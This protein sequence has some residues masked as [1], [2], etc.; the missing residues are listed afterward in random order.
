M[1]TTSMDNFVC[2]R[3]QQEARELR[4]MDRAVNEYWKR[5]GGVR[6]VA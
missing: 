5:S 4:E 3:C 2:F 6:R 1:E